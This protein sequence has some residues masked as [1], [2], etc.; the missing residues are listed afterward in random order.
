MH[1]AQPDLQNMIA[2]YVNLKQTVEYNTSLY[3]HYKTLFRKYRYSWNFLRATYAFIK[4]THYQTEMYKAQVADMLN[5]INQTSH[6]EI[7]V[8]D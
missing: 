6:V 1:Q 8:T 7:T 3:N 2:Q 5:E 4:M